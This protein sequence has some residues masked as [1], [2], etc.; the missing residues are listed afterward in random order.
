MSFSMK[1]GEVKSETDFR[2]MII[3]DYFLPATVYN[4]EV[5]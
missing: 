2:Y 3:T 1:I 4:I 5:F